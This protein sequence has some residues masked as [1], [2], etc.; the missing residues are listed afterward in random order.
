MIEPWMSFPEDA[1][2][3]IVNVSAAD[4]RREP[5]HE[6]EMLTQA[7]LGSVATVEDLADEGRWVHVRFE[8]DYAGWMRAWLLAPAGDEEARAWQGRE[9]LLVRSLGALVRRDPSDEAEAVAPVTLLG[10][11]A[12]DGRA[13]SGDWRAVSLPDGRAGWI[14]LSA[15]RPYFE[16]TGT[17]GEDAVAAARGLLGVPY[18]WGGVTPAALDCSGLTSLAW[19]MAGVTLRRDA[20]MQAA[21][22]EPIEIDDAR[23]GDLLFFG[24]SGER[25][26]H[27]AI[28]ESAGRF[29]HAQG[30]VRRNSLDKGAPDFHPRLALLFRGAGRAR[31]PQP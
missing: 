24:E 26:T 10:R 15:E 13:P 4:V 28:L 16:P 20:W 18:L 7:L 11:L 31:A 22:A 30:Y 21:D 3:A 2:R 29:L 8:D 1:P 6:A 9:A 14:P 25:V 12:L 27:V 19:R 23:P 17:A 5:A